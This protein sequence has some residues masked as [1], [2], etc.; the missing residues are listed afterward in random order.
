MCLFYIILA[1]MQ[2][3]HYLC[4]P[5]DYNIHNTAPHSVKYIHDACMVWTSEIGSDAYIRFMA[6]MGR[7]IIFMVYSFSRILPAGAGK[8]DWVYR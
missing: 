8:Q 6:N 2:K 7:D 1:R 4:I 5:N 3:K